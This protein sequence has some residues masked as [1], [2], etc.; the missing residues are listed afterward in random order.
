MPINSPNK[1]RIVIAKGDS[2]ATH[3]YI[4]PQD[5]DCLKN[6]KPN[7]TIKVTL[8]NAQAISSTT[9]G[10]LSLHKS[11]SKQGRNAIILPQLQSSSLISLGQLCDDDCQVHLDKKKLKVYKNKEI[12]LRGIR[13]RRDGLWDMLLHQPLKEDNY[14]KPT[15]HA[16]LCG[17]TKKICPI[18]S[19]IM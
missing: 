13:N 8:P 3:H 9:Q 10:D 15:T 18:I 19:L 1:N 6:R 16:A 17:I 12:I 14:I 7:T 5:E 4:R 2:G 11:I